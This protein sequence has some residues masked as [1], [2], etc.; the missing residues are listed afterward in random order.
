M[1]ADWLKLTQGKPSQ[2]LEIQPHAALGI[3]ALIRAA[4]AW[5]GIAAGC[6]RDGDSPCP[7]GL[8][9]GRGTE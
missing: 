7:V 4:R 6:E 3:Q 8:P 2:R 5:I 1:S 9:P